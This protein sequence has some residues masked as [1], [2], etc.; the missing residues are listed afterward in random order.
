MHYAVFFENGYYLCYAL[1]GIIERWVLFLQCITQYFRERILL[2]YALRGIFREWILFILC[3]TKYYWG[4][5]IIFTMHYEVLLRAGYYLY[6][7]LRSILGSVYYLYYVLHSF[8]GSVYYLYY[9][10]HCIFREWVL[11]ILRSTKY[12][13]GLYTV[14]TMHN[15]VF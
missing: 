8:W 9:A 11:F 2:Y 6:C 1:R 3:R 7:A 13:W 4:L 14:F 10:L 15:A 12:Y 5:D